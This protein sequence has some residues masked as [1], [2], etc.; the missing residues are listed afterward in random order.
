M[1][2]FKSGVKGG[3][4]TLKKVIGK[5]E[6]FGVGSDAAAVFEV[7]AIKVAASERSLTHF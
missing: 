1:L 2:G 7:D 3:G 5:V 6:C 4:G